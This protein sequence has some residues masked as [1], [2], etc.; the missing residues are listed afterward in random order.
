MIHPSGPEVHNL[1]TIF[2]F[3]TYLLSPFKEFIDIH[4]NSRY[5]Y[6]KVIPY[7]PTMNIILLW[8]KHPLYYHT[9]M[10]LYIEQHYF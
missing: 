1:D 3:N 4:S 7:F 8:V 6:G 5:R 2:I 10:F 9:K